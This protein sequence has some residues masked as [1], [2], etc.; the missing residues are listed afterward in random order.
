MNEHCSCNYILPPNYI[1]ILWVK[2]SIM[3]RK[4]KKN[5][6]V[7]S[8]TFLGKKMGRKGRQNFLFFLIITITLQ[9]EMLKN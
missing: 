9:L 8:L 2:C 3:Y 5:I 1:A 6:S 4:V 7:F